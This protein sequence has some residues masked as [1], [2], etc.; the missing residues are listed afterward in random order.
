MMGEVYREVYL[1]LFV[2][3]RRLELEVDEGGD[4]FAGKFEHQLY[5]DEEDKEFDNPPRLHERCAGSVDNA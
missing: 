4:V 5:G 3:G 2:W 1:P